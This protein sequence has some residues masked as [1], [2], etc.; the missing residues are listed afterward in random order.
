MRMG[1]SKG[2]RGKHVKEGSYLNPSHWSDKF[3]L[4]VFSQDGENNSGLEDMCKYLDLRKGQ[5]IWHTK[6]DNSGQILCATI[7][8]NKRLRHHVC[9]EA[10]DL[11]RRQG[12][13]LHT[14]QWAPTTQWIPI[15][16]ADRFRQNIPKKNLGGFE[17][18]TSSCL[19]IISVN[20]VVLYIGQS[21]K[22]TSTRLLG[23]RLSSASK[24]G[25]TYDKFFRYYWQ[26]ALKS[27]SVQLVTPQK[28]ESFVV[29][30]FLADEHDTGAI[31]SEVTEKY[32]SNVSWALDQAERVL[33]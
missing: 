19:Y 15:S 3:S 20:D 11:N 29:K 24:D 22:N 9:K 1:R 31:V 7:S 26:Q 12:A 8:S 25:Q 33:I 17:E 32:R 16:D 4:V 10:D 27:W 23:D 2:A 18:I 14:A 5:P 30:S 6:K 13:H 21:Q 28:C